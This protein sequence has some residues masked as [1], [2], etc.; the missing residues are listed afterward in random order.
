MVII[1]EIYREEN[2]FK[3]QEELG[4]EELII[5]EDQFIFQLI[6]EIF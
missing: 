3:W 6:K 2:I 1:Y 5:L 4:D